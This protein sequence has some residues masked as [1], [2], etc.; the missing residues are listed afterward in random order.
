ML[1]YATMLAIDHEVQT[2]LGRLRAYVETVLHVTLTVEGPVPTGG[3]PGYIVDRYAI[4][5]ARLMDRRCLLVFPAG[6]AADT[7]DAI[8]KHRERLEGHFPDRLPIIVIETISASNRHRLIQRHIPFIVPGTQLFVPQ[9]ALDLREQFRSDQDAPGEMLTPSAQLLVMACL[10][11]FDLDSETATSLRY[12]YGY[13]PMTMGRAID[14]LESH[15]LIETHK[16]GKYRVIKMPLS[17]KGLWKKTRRLLASPVQRSLRVPISDIIL[18]AP[19]SGESGLAYLTD[20]AGPRRETRAIGAKPW[21][22]LTAQFDFGRTPRWD[23][24]VIDLQIWTYDPRAIVSAEAVDPISLWLSLPDLPDE[25]Y[26][27]AKAQLLKQAGL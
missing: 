16:L 2:L 5:E 10:N 19:L 23:E 25:R 26:G 3:L 8:A 24:P 14:E 27:L 4:I 21:Q 17:R 12:R 6:D 1:A 11:G 20:L 7:P 18:H 9:L 22:T 13:T 15:G